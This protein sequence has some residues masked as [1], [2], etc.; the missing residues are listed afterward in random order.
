MVQVLYALERTD[1]I[2]VLRNLKQMFAPGGQVILF[3]TSPTLGENSDVD[4]RSFPARLRTAA[5][6]VPLLRKLARRLLRKRLGPEQGWARDNECVR[7]ILNEAG[8]GDMRF[9]PKAGQAVVQARVGPPA[10]L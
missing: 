8:F 7:A 5:R 1:A 10:T 6:S 4:T 2:E 9:Q 3:N